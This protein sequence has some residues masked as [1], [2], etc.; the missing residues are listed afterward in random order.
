MSIAD[1]CSEAFG[2]FKLSGGEFTGFIAACLAMVVTYKFVLQATLAT[3]FLLALVA[4]GLQLAT[5]L[6]LP[7]LGNFL[8][9]NVPV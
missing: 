1:G 5:I 4:F 6:A 8:S 2:A 9:G 7:G 3:S